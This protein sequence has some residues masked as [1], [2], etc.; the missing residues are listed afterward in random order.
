MINSGARIAKQRLV[1]LGSGWS[2]FAL[3]R[4]IDAK[5]FDTTVISDRN[6][7][8]FT[9]LLASAAVGTI[10]FRAASES[11][12]QTRPDV[13]FHQAAATH[14]DA[15]KKL[16][17]VTDSFTGKPYSY[18]FDKLVIG[19][20]AESATFGI[21]GVRENALFLKTLADARAIR[22][23]MLANLEASSNPFL[24]DA[25]RRRLCSFVVV[26][27]GPT[28][29]ELIGELSDALKEATLFYPDAAP[30][31]KLT[32]VESSGQLL[33]S[34]DAKLGEYTRRAFKKRNIEVILSARVTK[35]SNQ[36]VHVAMSGGNERILEH[37]MLVWS[38]GIGPTE[39]LKS[40]PFEK[41]GWKLKVDE[42]LRLPAH[43]DIFAI[44]DISDTGLPATAQVAQQEGRF[45]AKVLN[46]GDAAVPPSAFVYRHLFS[47]AYIGQFSAIVD[48]GSGG[49]MNARGFG[50]FVLWRLAYW[51]T[52]V[53][54]RNKLLIPMFWFKT[55][56]LGRDLSRF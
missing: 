8:I 28:S 33:S 29:C 40:L 11:V 21:P 56:W 38:T 45:V 24:D 7:F 44:G 54:W 35:V 1:V 14:I 51:T 16:V 30:L 46:A 32:L 52:A 4:A 27:G 17:T 9:P 13:H 36:H 48:S 53:S 22:S 41:S 18:A 19:T 2:S 6:N 49:V 42:L 37:G 34:F 31:V 10:E 50:A 25:E 3:I 23:K 47:L 26:G 15:A 20:G 5:R 39:F 55:F 43:P 12:R